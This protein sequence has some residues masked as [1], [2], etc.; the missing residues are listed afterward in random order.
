M[1]LCGFSYL[2]R[3][4]NWAPCAVSV[5]VDVDRSDD[6]VTERPVGGAVRVND[7]VDAGSDRTDTAAS[8]ARQLAL[9]EGRAQQCAIVAGEAELDAAGW[10]RDAAGVDACE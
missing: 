4:S 1:R 7:D 8:S 9:D 3:R 6:R 10:D 5:V 2:R